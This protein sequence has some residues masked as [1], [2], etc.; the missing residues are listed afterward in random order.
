MHATYIFIMLVDQSFADA[1]Y[2]CVYMYIL[3]SVICWCTFLTTQLT[4]LFF[5]LTGKHTK[6]KTGDAHLTEEAQ[7]ERFHQENC[8]RKSGCHQMHFAG[9]DCHFRALDCAKIYF[10]PPPTQK[11]D[12]TYPRKQISLNSSA[13]QKNDWCKRFH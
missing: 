4:T 5:L 7:T 2:G 8:I 12:I 11:K 3:L 6:T 10:P 9:G 1:R 13:P